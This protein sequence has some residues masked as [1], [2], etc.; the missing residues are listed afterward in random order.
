S[1]TNFSSL[2]FM[3]SG[4]SFNV[5]KLPVFC[6]TGP[7]TKT[8]DGDFNKEGNLEARV[9]GNNLGVEVETIRHDGGRGCVILGDGKGGFQQL[10]PLESGFFENNDCKDMEQIMF[11]GKQLIITVSNQAKAKTFLLK[12]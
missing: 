9:V 5:N 8:I 12:E 7:I 3:S 11:N 1:A 2:A 4:N 10:S 6:Q